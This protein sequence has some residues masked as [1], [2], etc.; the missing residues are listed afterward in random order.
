M[1]ALIALSL[2]RRSLVF[3]MFMVFLAAGF[4]VFQKLNIE[5]Y[6]DPAPPMV[7][8]ITQDPGFSAEDMERYITIPLEVAAAG[9]PGLQNTRSV[10]LYG[11]SDIKLQFEYATDYWF[12]Q[13][14]VL[15]R[16]NQVQLPAGIQPLLSPTSPVGEVYRYQVKAPSSY[17]SEER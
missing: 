6:A 7:A 14:Q 2:S 11:L 15:N 8:L 12:A 16:V 13:Q 4:L 10:S 5:A 3:A 9:M 1:R 17:R